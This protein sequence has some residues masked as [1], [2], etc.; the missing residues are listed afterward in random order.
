L[1]NEPS[2]RQVADFGAAVL[3]RLAIKPAATLGKAELEFDLFSSLIES[4]ILDLRSTNFELANQLGA[5]PSRVTALRFRYGQVT[6][7]QLGLFK[8]L[9]QNVVIQGFDSP[10]G[11]LRISVEDKFYRELLLSELMKLNAFTDSSFR[12][13][14][15]TVAPDYLIEAIAN[16]N[17]ADRDQFKAVVVKFVRAKRV[18]TIAGAFGEVASQI[19]AGV[20]GATLHSILNI[21]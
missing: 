21:H 20:G 4:G 3:S 13:A 12:S 17:P 5:T 10:S 8:H 6:A 2:A 16:A 7:G 14:V 9:T 18:A 19:V 11:M 1:V 15:L